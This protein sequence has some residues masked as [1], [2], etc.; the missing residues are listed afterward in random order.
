MSKF[1]ILNVSCVKNRSKSL[2]QK[3]TWGQDVPKTMRYYIVEGGHE[4]NEIV[5]GTLKLTVGDDYSKLV[6]K[7]FSAYEYILQFDDWDYVVKADD[8]VYI[9]IY[10]LMEYDPPKGYDGYGILWDKSHISGP[11]YI[12]SRKAV[13][14]L[15]KVGIDE[16]LK[17]P[18]WQFVPEDY[19][20]TETL[21]KHGMKIFDCY[22]TSIVTYNVNISYGKQMSF[23]ELL[24]ISDDVMATFELTEEEIKSMHEFI[25]GRR[26]YEMNRL[27]YTI[28]DY[29]NRQK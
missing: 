12:L 25:K 23:Y 26:K 16:S 29:R 21:Y 6:N 2:T 10:K 13:E 20:I 7:V 27:F 4:K 24:A 15:V 8:D 9:D 28:G 11:V 17:P 5:D 3:I 22:G 18:T 1:I 14:L 19:C